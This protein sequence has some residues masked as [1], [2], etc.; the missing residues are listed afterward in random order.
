MQPKDRS[1]RVRWSAASKFERLCAALGASITN[2]KL[3]PA[4]VALLQDVEAEVRA[5]ASFNVV[6]VASLMDLGTVLSQ[7][8]PCV[9]QLTSDASEHVRTALASGINDLAPI[10]GREHTIEQLIP[11][12][13]NLLRDAS[14][15]VRCIARHFCGCNPCR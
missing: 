12:L 7:L 11:L 2:G 13:L 4:Y 9:Q 8:L 6:A 1:W 3:C 5:A 14:S 10:L 15:E